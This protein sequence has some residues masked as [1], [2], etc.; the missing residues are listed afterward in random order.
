LAALFLI[1]CG[2]KCRVCLVCARSGVQ[3]PGRP[4]LTQRCKWFATASFNIYASN[5]VALALWRGDG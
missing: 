1:R 2:I 5:S 4:N 3:I